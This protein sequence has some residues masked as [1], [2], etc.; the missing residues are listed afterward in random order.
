MLAGLVRDQR[1]AICRFEMD[2]PYRLAFANNLL[3]AQA[4][5]GLGSPFSFHTLLNFRPAS[6]HQAIGRETVFGKCPAQRQHIGPPQDLFR[7]H[8]PQPL[9]TF[10][11]CNLW[12]IQ[13]DLDP[14]A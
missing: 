14:A 3:D 6:G 9:G 7:E 11:G 1:A 10:E 12:G 4:P 13:D 5:P 2:R 8:P